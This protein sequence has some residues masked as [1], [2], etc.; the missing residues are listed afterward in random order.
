MLTPFGQGQSEVIECPAM[1]RPEP[2]RA[3]IV[4]D[5]FSAFALRAQYVAQVEHGL[6]VIRLQLYC[7][8]QT[9]ARR[10]GLAHL[11]ESDTEVIVPLG[12]I[13]AHAHCLAEV[14]EGILHL[15]LL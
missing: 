8:L 7:A 3:P 1:V 10:I 6:G 13:R 9:I 15:P 11:S 5:G 12:E 4:L 2:Q 14:R